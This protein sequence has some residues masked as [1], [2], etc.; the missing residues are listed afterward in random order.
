M[1]IFPTTVLAAT[2]FIAACGGEQLPPA[3]ETVD[4]ATELHAL[5]DDYFERTLELNPMRASAIGDDRFNDQYA[6]SIGPE[7]RAARHQMNEQYLARL[8]E[9]QEGIAAEKNAARIGE[10]F[11]VLVEGPAKY[12][13]GWLMGRTDGDIIVNFPGDAAKT[14]AK[15]EATDCE[16]SPS[17][18]KGL[19]GKIVSVTITES[20][21]HTLRGVQVVQSAVSSR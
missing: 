9:I 11:D 13:D 4:P 18:A 14:A 15:E 10:T 2:I 6:N 21:S 12:P 16:G 3:T 17:S 1:K 20:S 8:I 7:H 5:F 19:I